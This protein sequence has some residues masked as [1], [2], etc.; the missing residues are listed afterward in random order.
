MSLIFF[1]RKS[2]TGIYYLEYRNN[3]PAQLQMCYL[4]CPVINPLTLAAYSTYTALWP[5]KASF[6]F[7]GRNVDF[8]AADF[9]VVLLWWVL[10]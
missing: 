3:H 4:P 6:S 1:S 10:R 7:Q 8:H 5:S 9:F 2:V